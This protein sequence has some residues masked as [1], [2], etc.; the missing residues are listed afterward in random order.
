LALQTCI[1]Y[2][3]VK[4]TPHYLLLP[5]CSPNIQKLMV[6]YT[7]LYSYM[8]KSFQ[9][10]SFSIVLKE[11]CSRQNNAFPPK[12][13]WQITFQSPF[14]SQHFILISMD[15]VASSKIP[16]SSKLNMTQGFNS[17]LLIYA[18]VSES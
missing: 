15:L 17:V 2:A 13:P 10:F 12:F 8:D 7:T 5:L 3:L 18:I 9:Y 1:Y 16:F 14:Y 11:I 6:T 4:L